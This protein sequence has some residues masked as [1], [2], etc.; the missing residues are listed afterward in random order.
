MEVILKQFVDKLGDKNDVVAVR[1]GYALNYL[2][3]KGLAIP[4]TS[5]AKRQRAE[6]I[7]QMEHR[8]SRIRQE[9]EALAERIKAATISLTT[10]VGKDG[11]MYGSVTPLQ[12]HNAL[13]DQ[14][15]E[16]DRRRISLKEEVTAL[17][18]YAALITLHKEVKVELTFS[19]VEKQG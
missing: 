6:D 3:P 18:D 8:Q 17:G 9:A 7:K 5:G 10:L 12:L 16:V 15:V 4:A 1:D 19:V 14:G 11:K 13:K 2:I